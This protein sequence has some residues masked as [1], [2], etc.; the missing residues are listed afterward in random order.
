METPV[1]DA[2]F[3]EEN[4]SNQMKLLETSQDKDIKN[5][6]NNQGKLMIW[7]SNILIRSLTLLKMI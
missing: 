4:F 1:K 6:V 7:L 5:L 3:I 2:E